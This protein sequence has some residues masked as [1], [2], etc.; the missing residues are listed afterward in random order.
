V[1]GEV[2]D[3]SHSLFRM[4]DAFHLRLYP[5]DVRKGLEVTFS[6]AGYETVIIRLDSKLFVESGV[7]DITLP[8][9]GAKKELVTA[10]NE[11]GE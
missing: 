6:A 1:K 5:A 2:T 10:R 7:A 3:G 8:P 4:D 11:A 9:V